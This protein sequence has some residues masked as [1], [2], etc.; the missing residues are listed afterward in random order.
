MKMEIEVV[1][2]SAGIVAGVVQK[3]G[4]QVHAGQRLLIL[5]KAS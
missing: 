4:A 5:E 1:S 3:E 2:P